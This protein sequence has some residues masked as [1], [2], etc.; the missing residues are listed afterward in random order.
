[1]RNLQTYKLGTPLIGGAAPRQTPVAAPVEETPEL[2]AAAPAPET[3]KTRRAGIGG[4]TLLALLA[5]DVIATLAAVE[6]TGAV[7]NGYIRLVTFG[8]AIF[9]AAGALAAVAIVFT[10]RRRATSRNSAG[11]RRFHRPEEL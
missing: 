7:H 1:M 2:P 11:R 3:P 8:A 5:L 10:S 4:K 6:A 9:V